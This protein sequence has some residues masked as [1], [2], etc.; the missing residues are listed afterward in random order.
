MPIAGRRLTG[1]V[2]AAGVTAAVLSGCDA[3]GSAPAGGSPRQVTVVGSGEVKGV[4]DTLTAD[5]TIEASAP[6]V[7][8]AMNQTNDRQKAVLNA[9][10]ASGVDAK[11][12]S[13][14][15]VSLAPQYSDNSV[16]S[17]YRASN[18]IQIKI[19][20]LDTASQ[21]LAN[22]V[23]AGGDATRINSVS[24]SIED[25]SKLVNDARARAFNNAKER[26]QQYADLSGLSLGTIISISE[27]P[28]SPAPPQPMPAPMPRGAMASEV[29]LQ[30]GEQTV[31]FAVTAVWELG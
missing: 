11:D 27:A 15:Q 24:Y 31:G 28:G 5:V 25:D 16:I 20:K 4:P 2:A 6:D 22:V 9:L 18:S 12:I 21:V 19:R 29:P 7:T 10:N 1:L 13:T 14:T 17:G 23:S 8:T 3:A 30:P 26:A